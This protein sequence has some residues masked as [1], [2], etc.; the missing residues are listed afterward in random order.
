MNNVCMVMD[1]EGSSSTAIMASLYV[2]LGDSLLR[3]SALLMILMKG[4]PF[5]SKRLWLLND[6]LVS[7]RWVHVHLGNTLITT[8]GGARSLG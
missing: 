5:K 8:A 7:G 6:L 1:A 4:C 3:P 2:R